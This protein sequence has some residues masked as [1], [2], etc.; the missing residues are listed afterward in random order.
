MQTQAGLQSEFEASRGC[1]VE[2]SSKNKIHPFLAGEFVYKR[3][4]KKA[5]QY[6]LHTFAQGALTI[7]SHPTP[8]G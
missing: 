2:T 8:Q 5:R 7:L 6:T 1:V 3:L 4:S